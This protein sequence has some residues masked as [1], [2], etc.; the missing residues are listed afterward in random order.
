VEEAIAR[1]RSNGQ[2]S[3]SAA[4][5]QKQPKQQ[6]KPKADKAKRQKAKDKL[7]AAGR[8]GSPGADGA[9]SGRPAMSTAVRLLD[10]E[11]LAA[12]AKAAA[13]RRL[14]PGAT[15]DALQRFPPLLQVRAPFV[16]LITLA[17][18]PT[19]VYAGLVPLAPRSR[20]ACAVPCRSPLFSLAPV[21]RPHSVLAALAAV[22]P[23]ACMLS[24][25][26]VEPTPVQ[27]RCWPAALE[28]CDV[29]A[30]ARGREAGRWRGRTCPAAVCSSAGVAAWLDVWGG[31]KGVLASHTCLQGLHVKGRRGSVC[32]AGAD[33]G[34]RRA[35]QRQ[36]AR[37]PAARPAPP[38][39]GLRWV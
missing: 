37:L 1:T 27:E 6:T 10:P 9:A 7:K 2:A 23:Q 30:S 13:L 20:A 21:L 14:P 29:Q 11:S 32:H 34:P 33:A 15:A 39:G 18:S 31:C 12:N 38:Q 25:H 19:C 35:G 26:L 17:Y 4:P 22:H 3:T 24:L 5:S 16:R 28:G 36:D 8:E